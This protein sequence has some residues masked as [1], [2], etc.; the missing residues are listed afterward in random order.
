MAASSS[1]KSWPKQIEADLIEKVRKRGIC[2]IRN[3]SITQKK[4]KRVACD[5]VGFIL[6][7]W[8]SENSM[9]LDMDNMN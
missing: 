4:I 3:T 7:H 8:W 5:E 2:G 1:K 6:G 9:L